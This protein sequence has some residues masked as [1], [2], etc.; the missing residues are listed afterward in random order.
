MSAL[1]PHGQEQGSAVWDSYSQ[2]S[3]IRLIM[4]RLILNFTVHLKKA[5]GLLVC[6]EGPL[7]QSEAPFLPTPRQHPGYSQN[8]RLRLRKA[9]SAAR[10]SSSKKRLRKSIIIRSISSSW[11]HLKSGTC[12]VNKA[13]AIHMCSEVE[14]QVC[15]LKIIQSAQASSREA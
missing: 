10:A 3:T 9:S 13:E 7:V 6:L 1:V 12:P 2:P 8:C 11:F 14:N 5:L 15:Q 4:K